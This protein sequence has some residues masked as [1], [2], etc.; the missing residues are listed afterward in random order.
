[1]TKQREHTPTVLYIYSTTIYTTQITYHLKKN[2]EDTW[3]VCI[4]VATTKLAQ[5]T[6]LT[7]KAHI[8]KRQFENGFHGACL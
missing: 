4:S 1:M 3:Q 5:A 2:P 8:D 6:E 7:R